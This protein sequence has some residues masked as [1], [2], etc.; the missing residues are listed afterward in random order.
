MQLEKNSCLGLSGVG[1]VGKTAMA[2]L[3]YETLC[4]DGIFEYTCFVEGAKHEKEIEVQVGKNI[5]DRHGNYIPRLGGA[6]A[7]VWA[8]V[9]GKKLLFVFD[10]I[11]RVS[12]VELLQRI[13]YENGCKHFYLGTYVEP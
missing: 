7:D 13:V 3:V 4:A 1:G 5:R 9:R 11:D 8:E 10:D 2:K 6:F 12:D